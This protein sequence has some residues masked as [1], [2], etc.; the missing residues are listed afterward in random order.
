[1]SIN[2]CQTLCRCRPQGLACRHVSCVCVPSA[3]SVFLFCKASG[4]SALLCTFY[5]C[6]CSVLFCYRFLK[7]SRHIPPPP[8]LVLSHPCALAC[9]RN[10]CTC[11]AHRGRRRKPP[12]T[13]PRVCLCRKALEHALD[14][15]N[16]SSRGAK[17]ASRAP[18]AR[19][20]ARAR[21]AGGLLAG[22]HRGWGQ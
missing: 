2:F 19:A 8:P 14:S 10:M 15:L 1:M 20:W 16:A 7:E 4:Q 13:N 12:C 22:G 18:S 17:D 5:R 3:P 9:I 6:S 11:L 21:G